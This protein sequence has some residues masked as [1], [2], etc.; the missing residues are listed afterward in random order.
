[1]NPNSEQ[2]DRHVG[3]SESLTHE[4]ERSLS[5]LS[6]KQAEVLK[7]YFGIG[8]EE[9]VS[10]EDIGARYDLTRERVRQIKDKALDRLKHGDKCKLLRSYLG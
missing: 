2:A 9:P 10:L 5:M 8:M 1:E 3:Y 4:V 7:M 6:Q